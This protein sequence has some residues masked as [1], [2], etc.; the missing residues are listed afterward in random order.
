LQKIFPGLTF[1][2]L[3]EGQGKWDGKEKSRPKIKK[4]EEGKEYGSPTL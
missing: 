1:R 3:L 2:T 4:K